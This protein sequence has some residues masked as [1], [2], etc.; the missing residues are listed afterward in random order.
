M[1][2]KLL[3]IRLQMPSALY[4]IPDETKTLTLLFEP[5]LVQ[6]RSTSGSIGN[7]TWNV[8]KNGIIIIKRCF[9]S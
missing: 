9:N 6:D 5:F 2:S 8:T 7:V 1:H 3:F 4:L